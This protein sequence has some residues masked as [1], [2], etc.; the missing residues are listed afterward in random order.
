[1][2]LYIDTEVVKGGRAVAAVV[3][4]SSGAYDPL[5]QQIQDAIARRTRVRLPIVRDAD[6]K[7]PFERNYIILGNRTTNTL[8]NR[9]YDLYYTYLDLKYPGRGGYEVRSLHNPFGN[10]RNAIFVGASDD[11]GMKLAV[12]EFIRLATQAATGDSLVLGWTMR[13]KLGQGLTPPQDP[14]AVA[15]WSDSA[16][17]PPATYFGWNSI[18]RRLALYYMTGDEKWLREFLWLAFPDEK[19]KDHIW[20]VDGERIEDKDHPLSGPYHYNGHHMILLWDLVEESPFFTDEQRLRITREFAEQLRHWQAEWCYCGR[21]YGQELSSI[22]TRHDQWAAVNLYCLSRYFD[23]Y[24]PHIIWRKNREA[25]EQ[26]FSAFARTFNVA[27]ELDHLWW[28]TTSYEPLMTY[29]VLS[30]DRRGVDNGHLE[31]LLRGYDI[32]LQ[33]RRDGPYLRQ[34]SLSFAHLATY[35]TGDGR[36]LWYRDMAGLDTDIFRIGQSFWPTVKPR[37]PEEIVGKA[38]ARPLAPGESAGRLAAIRVDQAFQFA[39]WRSGLGPDADYMLLD[40]FYGGSRNPY[41]C[42]CLTHLRHTDKMLLDGYLNQLVARQG[43]LVEPKAPY[44]AALIKRVGFRN[45]AYFEAEVPDFSFGPWRRRLFH[46]AGHWTLVVDTFTAREDTPALELCLQ[47][48]LGG[49]PRAEIDGRVRFSVGDAQAVMVPWERLPT[50]VD[51]RIVRFSKMADARKGDTMTVAT[52]IGIEQPGRQLDCLKA[53]DTHAC[54]REGDRV[55]EVSWDPSKDGLS[56]LGDGLAFFDASRP[57]VGPVQEPIVKTSATADALWD[58]ERKTLE[59]YSP[60]SALLNL[61]VPSRAEALVDGKKTNAWPARVEAGYHLVTGV[62]MPAGM[63]SACSSTAR[64]RLAQASRPESSAP[65]PAGL[66]APEVVPD[67][68]LEL[69]EQVKW[70]VDGAGDGNPE[71]YAAGQT[72]LFPIAGTT[73]GKPMEMPAEITALA[74][75]PEQK[76]LLVGCR[77]DRVYAYRPDGTLAWTFVSEMHPEVLKSGKTYWFKSALPGISGLAT[78]N[79]TGEGTQVFV[80]SACTVEVVD[81]QGKLI[82][83]VPQYW[84]SVWRMAVLPALDGSRKLLAA[85]M[86]N[87]VNDVGVIDGTSWQVSYGFTSLPT[88]HSYI[89]GWSSMNTPNLIVADLDGDGTSEVVLDV[90]GSWN[91]VSA[92]S[93]DGKPLWSHS[94]GPSL[95]YP[96]RH[97]RGLSVADLDGNGRKEVVAADEGG[98]VTA[99]DCAGERLW[100]VRLPEAPTAVTTVAAGTKALAAVGTAAGRVYFIDAEGNVIAR[101]PAVNGSIAALL[102]ARRE[103]VW[104]A[105]SAG[106]VAHL[107]QPR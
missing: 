16:M 83:R 41:H 77:D 19:A 105:T 45:A 37:P 71:L 21:Y 33:H 22:G 85:K 26:Y 49:S 30:G 61:P 66:R 106:I 17:Y 82:R 1:K 87:G 36:F 103:G 93:A 32:L 40:G 79:L 86:P 89:E 42:L 56:V 69:G 25:A 20:K 64:R 107:P 95:N 50:S 14:D 10:G 39:G 59:V 101:S 8:V 53:D 98:I 70:L 60:A 34:L 99:F 13:I 65:E 100:A 75:W 102:P 27:G 63:A 68:Q 2:P 76:L 78:G 90:N 28:Y 18:S 58:D 94:F 81:A 29:M 104:I 73:A 67:V 44:G 88:G 52:L 38:L 6:V 91:R 62:A 15:S 35:L 92:Y 48:Q 5:A 24:Y 51:G 84:G 72:R 55:F 57:G 74:Y 23:K 47:W 12:A 4:P 3:V 43:G 11:E 31:T 80:G 54:V 7:L 96:H 46:Y 9:L 97:M